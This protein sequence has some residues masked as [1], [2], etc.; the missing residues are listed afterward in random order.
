MKFVLIMFGLVVVG[1]FV[2]NYE[3]H[4]LR[5]PFATDYTKVDSFWA[6]KDRC[7]EAAKADKYRNLKPYCARTTGMQNLMGTTVRYQ[8]ERDLDETAPNLF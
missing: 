7:R 6:I 3:L 1:L 5:D 4:V 2:P 8:S